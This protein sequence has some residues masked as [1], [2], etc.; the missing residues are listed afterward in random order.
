MIENIEHA[1]EATESKASLNITRFPNFT[2]EIFS[3]LDIIRRGDRVQ[4]KFEH[5][6][7]INFQWPSLYSIWTSELRGTLEK[8]VTRKLA[9]CRDHS[10]RR[11]PFNFPAVM[12]VHSPCLWPMSCEMSFVAMGQRH[13]SQL[14]GCSSQCQFSVPLP[15]HQRSEMHCVI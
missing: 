11:P 12:K 14:Q 2:A 15:M 10:L 8:N 3:I 1:A 4:S 7:I 6:A 5:H 9:P 13:Q